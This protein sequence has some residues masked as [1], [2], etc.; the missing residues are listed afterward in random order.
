MPAPADAGAPSRAQAQTEPVAGSGSTPLSV[1]PPVI[2]EFLFRFD[3]ALREQL[4]AVTVQG[5]QT[6][7]LFPVSEGRVVD[8]AITNHD[9]HDA[10]HGE[11]YARV[12]D[13][14]FA[15]AVL[16]YVDDAVAGTI[17]TPQGELFQV[18]YAGNG[19]HRVTQLDPHRFPEEAEPLPAPS[20]QAHVVPPANGP[21]TSRLSAA[22]AAM[23]ESTAPVAMAGDQIAPGVNTP[24]AF[25]PTGMSV[26][27]PAPPISEDVVKDPEIRDGTD[28]VVDILIVYTPASRQ[29]N[30]G[31]SGMNAVINAAVAKANLAY[32]NSRVPLSLRVV[33]TAEVSHTSTGSIGADLGALQNASDGKMD[34]VY[35]LRT[36][37]NADVVSL[38]VST[39]DAAGVAYLL[40]PASGSNNYNWVFSVV[41]DIYADGNI[42]F[43]HEVGHNFGCGH[44]MGNG[45]GVFA[46]SNG[47]R[48]TASGQEYRTVMA[49]APG[50]RIPYFSNPSVTYGGVA[51]G[52]TSTNNNADTLTRGR[53]GHASLRMSI[54][55][56]S[57][58][59]AG[60]IN[61]DTKPDLI[62]R[63][64]H[65]GITSYWNLD[66][67]TRT[68]AAVLT[69]NAAM[70]LPM[71]TGD[72]NADAMTDIVWYNSSNGQVIV[73]YMDGA[74]MSGSATIQPPTAS[75]LLWIPTLSG[76]FDGDNVVDILWRHRT[77]G[78]LVVWYMN[79]LTRTGTG[80]VWTPNSLDWVP[81][82]SG[83]FN[84]DGKVDLILRRSAT[85]QVD[86]WYMDGITHT[87]TVTLLAGANAAEAAW[88]PMAAGDFNGDSET[89]IVWRQTK[90]GNVSVWY[91]NDAVRT[92]V[93][94]IAQ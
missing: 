56:Y 64:L 21:D 86:L 74:A 42:S 33:H 2:S 34:N 85:G 88:R 65:N 89:D 83:D 69:Q 80:T 59:T 35:A 87:S 31:A 15:D 78:Q 54:H 16:A 13:Q 72:F 50:V 68:S 75:A 61:N 91:M 20:S 44:G 9:R 51:T 6:R 55:D 1:A 81:M 67:V 84:N 43:A 18:R 22:M 32:T 4:D 46:N 76:D 52:T 26:Y 14:P 5:Q 45:G 8:L 37:Y 57:V 17:L 79:G 39:G 11:L 27:D 12:D 62:W 24:D 70:W 82:A 28:K 53:T 93:A 19:V 73:W 25:V 66:G 94:V 71:F 49:Y 63:N 29:K 30:G 38:F 47:Y 92:G 58:T 40:N 10:T 23:A 7:I 90:T 77:T 60:D 36:Q 3:A 41:V 48:F